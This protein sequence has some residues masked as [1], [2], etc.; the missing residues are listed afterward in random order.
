[1]T[2]GIADEIQQIWDEI[3]SPRY[4]EQ[5]DPNAGHHVSNWYCASSIILA[6][7][8]A[9][10]CKSLHAKNDTT[11]AG[12]HVEVAFPPGLVFT[13]KPRQWAVT[14]GGAIDGVTTAFE[15][16]KMIMEVST[17]IEISKTANPNGDFSTYPARESFPISDVFGAQANGVVVISEFL[18]RPSLQTTSLITY[19]IEYGQCLHFPLDDDGLI[20][21]STVTGQTRMISLDP[22]PEYT[23]L[24]SRNSELEVRIDVKPD[25]NRDP[26]KVVF[27][28][29]VEGVHKYTFSPLVVAKL[30]PSS[31]VVCECSQSVS[32]LSVPIAQRWQP[33]RMSQL[34]LPPLKNPSAASRI[35]VLDGQYLFIQAGGDMASQLLCLGLLESTR[36]V[37][38]T[39]CLQCSYKKLIAG[40]AGTF[41]EG[42]L[43]NGL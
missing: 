18:V 17:A 8:Y 13:T 32:S 19:H 12:L 40:R 11:D 31:I 23:T 30:L 37:L 27:H 20:R 7:I 6:T 16:T 24:E 1:M 2:A 28:A 10:M 33:V 41:N 14:I 22:D 21:V 29:R 4:Y 26:R 36:L 42:V 5:M 39:N 25:W 38:A 3:L 35:G 34:F 9:A 15:W 43:I